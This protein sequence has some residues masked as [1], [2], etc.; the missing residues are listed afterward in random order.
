MIDPR[1]EEDG[2]TV[3]DLEA[4]TELNLEIRDALTRAHRLAADVVRA[5]GR[6]QQA[7]GDHSSLREGL[8]AL[9]DSLFSA[10]EPVS[11]PEPKLLNQLSYL[12]GMTTGA[13]YRPGEDAYERLEY[14][15]ERIAAHE[16]RFSELA[17][18]MERALR[19]SGQ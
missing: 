6:V 8:A 9:E 13:D 2:T 16:Q 4:Q 19:N 18:E 11:Y 7:S 12:Y 1:V 5:Q 17:D 14:L 3:A 10:R 15:R